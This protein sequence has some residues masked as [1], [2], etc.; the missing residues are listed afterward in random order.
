M[1]APPG[2]TPDATGFFAAQRRARLILL[3]VDLPDRERRMALLL[4]EY[5]SHTVWEARQELIMWPGMATLC[6]QTGWIKRRVQRSREALAKA[7]V[8]FCARRGG[9]VGTARWAIS[10]DWLAARESA[11]LVSGALASFGARQ[12]I[13]AGALTWATPLE[14]IQS[15]TQNN[16]KDDKQFD[17]HST[18][19]LGDGMGVAQSADYTGSISHNAL[20][21]RQSVTLAAGGG[22][23]GDGA[24]GH[25]QTVAKMPVDKTLAAAD[26]DQFRATTLAP[27][28]DS[29]SMDRATS[30]MSPEGK[31]NN[32]INITARDGEN[33]P[34]GDRTQRRKRQLVKNPDH[35]Q[36]L[37]RIM[38]K[39][40]GGR[41]ADPPPSADRAEPPAAI[42]EAV[43]PAFEA[44]ISAAMQSAMTA[45]PALVAA[46]LAG[47]G[48]REAG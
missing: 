6:L 16:G 19:G 39:I 26:A 20:D 1:T 38:T 3:T 14:D 32:I 28:G 15:V 47:Q 29:V 21:D 24:C 9:R 12:P 45:L 34:L 43:R 46:A 18:D 8:F 11:L 7:G 23:L 10:Q 33:P 25:A 17:T 31:N 37:L 48:K 44:A 30:S 22:E 36:G 2:A 41:A 35:R 13:F 4:L 5:A 42:I 27:K 40:D